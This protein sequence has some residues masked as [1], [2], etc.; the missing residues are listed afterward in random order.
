MG[1]VQLD[2]KILKL[3]IEFLSFFCYNII[4]MERNDFMARLTKD[5][6]KARKLYWKKLK[7]T[8][9]KLKKAA[10][11]WGPWD[12]SYA[13][14]LFITS[15]EG[16]KWYYEQ[17]YNVWAEDDDANGDDISRAEKCACILNAFDDWMTCEDYNLENKEWEEFCDVVKKYL[18][19]LWD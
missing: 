11:E 13:T 10:K 9:K 4:V 14:D 3:K 18:L 17:N 5:E 7:A 2:N 16:F 12:H 1:L 8:R 19:D 15:I 6:R